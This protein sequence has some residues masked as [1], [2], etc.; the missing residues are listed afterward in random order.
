MLERARR[1]GAPCLLVSPVPPAVVSVGRAVAAPPAVSERAGWAAVECVDRRGGR[2]RGAGSSPKS[3][4]AWPERCST[5][6]N[7]WRAAA[8]R[9]PLQPQRQ[10]STVGLPELRRTGSLHPVWSGGGAGWRAA[11]LSALWPGPALCVRVVRQAEDEDAPGR[12]EPPARGA[13]CA[14]RGRGGGGGRT[15]HDGSGRGRAAEVPP[16]LRSCS[17][18]RR[19]CTG[20]AG[21]SAVA[22]LDFDL[23]LLSPR[24]D[25]TDESLALLVRAGRLVGPRGGVNTNRRVLLQTRVPEHPVLLAAMR[26]TPEAV[27]ADEVEL[28]QASG[29]PPFSAMA[30]VSGTQAADVSSP[31][32][33]RPRP[34]TIRGHG[35]RAGG[36]SEG[37]LLRA[38]DHRAL[39]DTAGV[40]TP[41]GGTGPAHR[42]R[43]QLTV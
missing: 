43:P 3:S 13:G 8:A 31:P 22:F 6:P 25:A 36:L 33:K 30:L 35:D 2:S 24:L 14:A 23:H 26:G 27:L 18:P 16:T 19:C 37:H 29:L 34:G 39:C 41:A 1:D 15:R 28:R 38:P 21:P 32:R 7:E 12:G 10:G 9:L 40:G 5:T 11:A 20:R 17:A 42:G 4:S